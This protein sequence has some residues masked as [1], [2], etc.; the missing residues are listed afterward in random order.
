MAWYVFALVDAVPAGGSGKG[1]TGALSLRKLA[2]AFVVVESRA[3]A[4]SAGQ[5]SA[6]SGCTTAT[7]VPFGT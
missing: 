7:G 1:L 4:L 2:G 3:D 5:R 6:G